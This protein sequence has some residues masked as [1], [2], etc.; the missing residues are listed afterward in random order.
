[1][2]E[3][4]PVAVFPLCPPEKG[5]RY[6][7]ETVQ[8][9]RRRKIMQT[10]EVKWEDINKLDLWAIQNMGEDGYLFE[11]SDGRIQNILMSA[12]YPV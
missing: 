4:L 7:N 5:R 6:T 1:M 11:I 12:A 10:V 2:Q 8:K 3:R 9:R